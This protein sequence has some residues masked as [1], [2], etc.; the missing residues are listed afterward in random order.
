MTH[1][2]VGLA[3]YMLVQ[4]GYM[5]AAGLAEENPA[6]VLNAFANIVFGGIAMMMVHP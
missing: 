6:M 5:M 1:L 4:G 2:V 3:M